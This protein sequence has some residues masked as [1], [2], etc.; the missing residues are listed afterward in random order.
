MSSPALTY[1]KA[2]RIDL[3]NHQ[4]FNETWVRE[5]IEEDPSIL[6]L[7]DLKVKDV[8]RIQPKAGRLD[9]LLRDPK[10]EQRYE[11]E[12]MLGPTDESHIVRTIEYWNREKKYSPRYDHCAVLVAEQITSRFFEVIGLFHGVLP[13]IAIQVTALRV[14]DQVILQFTKVLEKIERPDE[15]KERD[16]RPGTRGE[17]ETRQLRVTD[18]CLAI[19]KEVD[20]TIRLNY[21]K[22]DIG[23]T[24]QGRVRNF[25][26]FCPKKGFT[27]VRPKV[28]D[29]PRWLKK[30]DHAGIVTL[31]GG[32][33]SKRVGFR[34]TSAEE[35]RRGRRLIRE[36]F[37]A[38]YNEQQG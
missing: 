27:T 15:P 26:M 12:L 1:T 29:R 8:E 34:L 24:V 10:T 32:S 18:E 16:G 20:P 36:L 13:I 14:G 25:V 38:S 9:L 30:L 2:E 23:L 21:R 5:R 4:Q 11:V 7:G 3:R 35:L 17:W 28:G 19:L 33:G 37:Q 22:R 6:G 31:R